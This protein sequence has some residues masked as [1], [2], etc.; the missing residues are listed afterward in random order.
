M[1]RRRQGLCAVA[2]L[3]AVPLVALAALSASETKV[4]FSC[5]G[6]GG[7]HINGTSEELSFQDKGDSL[8]LT[9]FTEKLTTGISLRDT[10]MHEKYLESEKYPTAELSV[11][12]QGVKFPGD[13]ETVNATSPGTL[14]LHGKSQPVTLHYK[15]VRK[16]K[17]TDVQGDVH[18]NMNDYE[19]TT[20]SYLGIKVQPQVD[21]TVTFRL[22]E[23]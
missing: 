17:A 8:L 1:R 12:R 11:P 20:P 18:I 19:I 3:C 13:G 10:H 6:P 4:G 2:L 21:I 14:T 15:A 5:I 9:V 16:G 23:T 22:L 7:L